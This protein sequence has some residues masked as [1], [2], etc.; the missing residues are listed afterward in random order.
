MRIDAGYREH[1]EC[2]ATD[3]SLAFE[4]ARRAVGLPFRWPMAG[5]ALATHGVPG[6]MRIPYGRLAVFHESIYAGG[7]FGEY[8]AEQLSHPCQPGARSV[9]IGRHFHVPISRCLANERIMKAMK[10]MG[11]SLLAAIAASDAIVSAIAHT[12]AAWA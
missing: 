1:A 10:L 8:L 2:A 3:A 6:A 9:I 11:A 4:T 12:G 7:G 5:L